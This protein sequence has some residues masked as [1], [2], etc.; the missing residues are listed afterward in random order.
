M[1]EVAGGLFPAKGVPIYLNGEDTGL[2][3]RNLQDA[4]AA[5]SRVLI[6]KGS[7]NASP[8]ALMDT[9]QDVPT[10][11]YQF[12]WPP[13]SCVILTKGARPKRKGGA[14]GRQTA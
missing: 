6:R 12:I 14:R 2:A 5:L 11:D 1:P 10:R 4:A 13:G 3:A 7:F 9:L 8:Q